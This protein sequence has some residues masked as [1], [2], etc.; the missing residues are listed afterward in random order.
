MINFLGLI[1]GM[2][3]LSGCSPIKI[4]GNG[5]SVHYLIIGIGVVTIPEAR[6]E[7]AVT[8][9]KTNNFGIAI[10]NQPGLKF[11]AGY[12]SGFFLAVPDYAKDVRVEVHE[13]LGGAIIVDTTNAE[14]GPVSQKGEK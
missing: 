4:I 10:S 6:S 14:L 8:A 11:S 2:L 5:E 12:S 9:A 7:I 13:Q 3:I 1:F